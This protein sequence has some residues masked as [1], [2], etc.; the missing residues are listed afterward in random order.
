MSRY[1]RKK[2]LGIFAEPLQCGCG[3]MLI[4]I[5][6]TPVIDLLGYYTLLLLI[7]VIYF[8]YKK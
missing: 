6:L 2:E 8:I 4:G 5:I 1:F 3:L 7:P